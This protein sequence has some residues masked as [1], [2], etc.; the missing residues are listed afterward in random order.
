MA[1]HRMSPSDAFS[2]PHIGTLQGKVLTDLH[3]SGFAD[4]VCV[5]AAFLVDAPTALDKN[6]LSYSSQ[7]PGGQGG[8]QA[9]GAGVMMGHIKAALSSSVASANA[10]TNGHANGNAYD[11]GSAGTWI[12]VCM[13]GI[14]QS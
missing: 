4:S 1:Y 12:N 3:L 14:D 2:P 7:T 8:R 10:Y 5:D 9:D 13:C 11:N 6:P